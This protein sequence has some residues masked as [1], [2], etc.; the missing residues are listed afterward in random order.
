MALQ[1]EPLK[2]RDAIE[3]ISALFPIDETRTP[4]GLAALFQVLDQMDPGEVIGW[5]E[6]LMDKEID[7]L[8]HYYDKAPSNRVLSAIFLIL[9]TRKDS[10]AAGPLLRFFYCNPNRT[11]LEWIAAIWPTLGVERIT[12]KRMNWICRYFAN[13]AAST[14]LDHAAASL[15]KGTDP[16]YIFNEYTTNLPLTW[17]LMDYVFSRGGELVKRI[18]SEIAAILI[19]QALEKGQDTRVHNFLFFYPAEFWKPSLLEKIYAKKGPPD[20]VLRPFYNVFDSGQLWG[21]RNRLF[22]GRMAGLVSQSDIHAFWT[23]WLYL[24]QDWRYKEEQVIAF[25]RPFRVFHSKDRIRVYTFGKPDRL[26]EEV[27]DMDLWERELNRI[28]AEC[29]QI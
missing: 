5:S 21:F 24:C 29:R 11:Q 15:E 7:L 22:S 25:I 10:R 4:S 26:I 18:P 8:S 28:L 27:D 16:T 13:G 2:T 20:P 9:A 3:R 19:T 12:V 14:P 1:F 23:D 6:Q 17:L